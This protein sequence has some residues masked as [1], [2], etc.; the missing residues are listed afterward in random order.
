MPMKAPAY[1][2]APPVKLEKLEEEADVIFKA[3]AVATKGV[4]D[5]W[6]KPVQDFVARE[7]EFKVVAVVK[8][9]DLG[10]SVRFRHYDESDKPMGRVYQPQFYHFTAGKTYLVF[11]KRTEAAGVLRQLWPNHKGREDQ[12]VLRCANDR[13]V[14]ARKLKEVVW[15]EL[16][17]L[18]QSRDA[19]DATYAL[20]QLDAMSGADDSFETTKDFERGEV[21]K[22]VGAM[23]ASDDGDVTRATI[24]AIGSKNPYLCDGQAEYWLATV[25][26]GRIPGIGQ[27]DRNL[28]NSGGKMFA[29]E[30]MSLADG[31]GAVETRALAIRALGLAR[32]AELSDAVKRW[33][34]VPEPEVRAAATLLLADLPDAEAAKRLVTLVEDPAPQVRRCTAH[35]IGFKQLPELAGTLGTLLHDRDPAVRQ[36][37]SRSLCSFS[38]KHEAVAK[39]LRENLENAEFHPLFLNAL[40]RENPEKYLDQLAK[41]VVERTEPTNWSGGQVPSFTAFNILFKYLQSLPAGELRAGKHD[42]YLDAMEKGYVTGSSEPR[43]IYAFYVQRGMAGRAKSYRVA[44]KKQATFDLDYFFNQVD[45]NPGAYTRE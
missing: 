9:G 13:P 10:E 2:V 11:A 3:T 31:K 14:T 30:L 41:V 43:D 27:R 12:G 28:Q 37:A 8:G 40:A 35:A 17:A 6:F 15:N 26:D 32:P 25:G 1:L 20:Q 33:L 16:M 19:K 39:V 42:R 4:E 5:P 22:A 24:M 7:T 36:A 45:Q 23:L 44:A 29:K 18:V 21:L 34:M 38:T